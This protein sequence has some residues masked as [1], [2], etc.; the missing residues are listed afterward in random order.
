VHGQAVA[1]GADLTRRALLK[2]AL[3]PR[4]GKAVETK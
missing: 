2:K 1:D 4:L 3:L